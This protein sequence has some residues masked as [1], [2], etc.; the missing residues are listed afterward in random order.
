MNQRAVK[1]LNKYMKRKYREN[2][3]YYI[4]KCDISKFFY[5]INKKILYSIIESKVKDRDFLEFTKK[6]I[7]Q[8][9]SSN[10]G[11][12]IGNYTSQY[13]AN[14]YLNELDHYI[15]EKLK[16]KYYVRYMDDFVLLLDNKEESKEI[17]EKIREFLSK[18]L[19]LS[20]NKKTNYLK[21]K[22][23]VNFC[24][25]KLKGTQITLLKK[26]KKK[27]YKNVR[28]WNNQYRAKNLD[29]KKTIMQLNSWQGHAS[30]T[31]K[32]GLIKDVLN[33]CEWLYDEL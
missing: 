12:P 26:S 19:R 32:I 3:D 7:F 15:K 11:I 8:R 4:L 29:F 28:I 24:G 20:L 2:P 27:I 1:N 13:F 23:G 31:T 14:I 16:V 25:Y 10:T 22:Q 21:N 30:H 6:I 33:K 18:N 5:S 17:L 9:S